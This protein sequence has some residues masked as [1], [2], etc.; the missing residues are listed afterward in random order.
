M[1]SD[2]AQFMKTSRGHPMLVDP[3]GFYYNKHTND[4]KDTSK[5]FWRCQRR[6]KN[7]K[8][9]ARLVTNGFLITKYINEHDHKPPE[10]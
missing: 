10:S 5:V 9:R 3:R 7:V 4:K 2:V 6:G 1:I 8:C